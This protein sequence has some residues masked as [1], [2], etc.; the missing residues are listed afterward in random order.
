MK[1]ALLIY[2]DEQAWRALS[3]GEQA[4]MYTEHGAFGKW[5]AEKRWARG[6][7]E[8]EPSEGAWTVRTDGE[9]FVVSDGPYAE[10]KEQIAGIYLIEC[11]SLEDALEAGKR[12]PAQIVEV[13]RVVE[14]GERRS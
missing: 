3:E 7:E 13:R 4:K 10:T 8:L 11:P 14:D 1:F 6:G 12:L 2:A 5:L 9:A